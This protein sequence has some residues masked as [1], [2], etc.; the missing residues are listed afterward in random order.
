MSNKG[1]AAIIPVLIIVLIAST[2]LVGLSLRSDDSQKK[3]VGKVLSEKSGDQSESG[4]SGSGKSSSDSQ[5]EPSGSQN[6]TTSVDSTGNS[7]NNQKVE[8]ENEK[9]KLKIKTK[10]EQT[11]FESE[12]ESEVEAGKEKTKIKL[13]GIKL[14]V[15]QEGD[16]LVIKFKDENDKEVELEAT[17]EAEIIKDAKKELDDD[18]IQIAT[19]SAELGFTQKGRRVRTNFPL[20]VNPTTGQL[21]VTTP[22]GT[23][24]VAVLPQQAI[25]NMI[26]AGVLTRT[27]E[28][29]APPTLVGSSAAQVLSSGSSSIV[30]AELNNQPTYEISGI[31]E[32]KMLGIIP[33]DIKIKT[34]VSATDGSLVKI[35]EDFL[36][37][38]LDLLSF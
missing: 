31:K 14:E 16:R 25:E 3:A 10:N 18:D 24:M 34:F 36:T 19:G 11:G 35:Q 6:N 12:S 9:G 33:V 32:Q 20:S 15:E 4:G 17:E 8:I 28:P 5:N 13:A 23:K 37:R 2:G 38:L 1:F 26:E 7:T 29:Q 27:E 21:F 30:L 22:S